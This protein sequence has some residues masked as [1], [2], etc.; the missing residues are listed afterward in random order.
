MIGFR[1]F[2]LSCSV[3]YI[4]KF[5]TGK[6]FVFSCHKVFFIVI[7]HLPNSLEAVPCCTFR[8][9]F[10]SEILV[11]HDNLF[12]V[13]N[14]FE[15]TASYKSWN[16]QTVLPHVL[17]GWLPAA[18]KGLSLYADHLLYTLSFMLVNPSH[19]LSKRAIEK[20][21]WWKEKE[22][23]HTSIPFW[24]PALSFIPFLLSF[25]S[26]L[27]LIPFHYP[28][29]L[30]FPSSL[31]LIPFPHPFSLSFS[32][33]SVPHPFLIHFACHFSSSIFLIP[34]PHPF[35]SSL[36]LTLFH[37]HF[38]HP[39]FP[40][41]FPHLFCSSLSVISFHHLFP[42]SLSLIAF[43]HHFPSSR[44][45]HPHPLFLCSALLCSF[46]LFIFLAN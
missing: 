11:V 31:F 23:T 18:V 8:G 37:I 36:S 42:S 20:Y 32:I 29:P 35:S 44:R 7:L 28:F 21:S 2:A 27:S 39:L 34:V 24:P 38:S 41:P 6:P 46:F 45:Y 16:C 26:S 13:R 15:F 10:V 30:P 3:P 12:M 4:Y 43:P 9:I 25:S 5:W 33:I 40:I 14:S 1:T 17:L 19:M 22:F